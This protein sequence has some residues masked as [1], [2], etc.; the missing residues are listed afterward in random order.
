MKLFTTPPGVPRIPSIRR[1]T[2]ASLLLLA[3]AC[4]GADGPGDSPPTAR[5]P[6]SAGAVWTIDRADDRST[7]PGAMLA[8]LHGLHRVVIDGDNTFAGM[9]RLR[10]SRDTAGNR[11]LALSGGLTA[12]LVPE[13]D[14]LQLTFSTGE[15]VAL[16]QEEAK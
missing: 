14:L 11:L 15:T 2:L 9:T 13:G 1:W 16:R 8:Y 5:A 3:L 10:A 6:A 7:A 4:G 12:T